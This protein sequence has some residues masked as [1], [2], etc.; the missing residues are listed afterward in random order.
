[1]KTAQI[2]PMSVTQRAGLLAANLVLLSTVGF[3]ACMGLVYG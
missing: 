3:G 2:R 1:M